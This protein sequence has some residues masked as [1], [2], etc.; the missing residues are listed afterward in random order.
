MNQD[1]THLPFP[2]DRGNVHLQRVQ[3]ENL[4]HHYNPLE[5]MCLA[6]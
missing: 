1:T 6:V 3:D 5:S 2:P 4:S